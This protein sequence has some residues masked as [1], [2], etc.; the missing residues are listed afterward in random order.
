MTP[1]DFRRLALS[2]PGAEEHEHMHHPDFRAGGRIFATLAYPD[3]SFAM[4]KLFP[5]QQATFVDSDPDMFTPVK[6]GWGKQGCTQVHL[7]AATK[8]RV[9]EALALAWERVAPK[10]PAAGKTSAAAQRSGSTKKSPAKKRA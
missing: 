1:A 10:A 3:E 2:L 9:C 4:V 7:K 6:G 8:D 5:D